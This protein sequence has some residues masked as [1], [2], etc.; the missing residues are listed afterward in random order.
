MKLPIRAPGAI[1]L[2]EDVVQGDFEHRD[3]VA[4][5]FVV[6]LRVCAMQPGEPCISSSGRKIA[7]R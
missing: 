2:A 4:A 6:S 7:K 1:S 5:F 3:Q